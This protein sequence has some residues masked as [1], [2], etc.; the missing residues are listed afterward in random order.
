MEE[1]GVPDEIAPLVHELNLPFARVRPRRAKWHFMADAA[2]ELQCL[3]AGRL[4]VA[5]ESQRA[6]DQPPPAS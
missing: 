6:R 4:A 1:T 3:P 2:H 5:G